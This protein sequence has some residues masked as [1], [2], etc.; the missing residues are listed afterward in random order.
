MLLN[1]F[2]KEVHE[3]NRGGCELRPRGDMMLSNVSQ[4]PNDIRDQWILP[5]LNIH[6]LLVFCKH[7][8]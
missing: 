3:N 6:E 1:W 2:L 8:R 5:G 4:Y 7:P